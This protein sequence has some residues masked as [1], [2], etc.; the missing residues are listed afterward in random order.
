MPAKWWGPPATPAWLLFTA[1]PAPP[2]LARAGI[3]ATEATGGGATGGWDPRGATGV[4]DGIALGSEG[5]SRLC[6]SSVGAWL[7]SCFSFLTRGSDSES[8][9][10]EEL[11]VEEELELSLSEELELLALSRLGPPTTST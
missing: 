2:L 6:G 1:Y 11:L 8:E 4:S 10:S 5:P 3:G 7:G 9:L